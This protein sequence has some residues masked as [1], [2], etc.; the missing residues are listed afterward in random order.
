[1]EVELPLGNEHYINTNNSPV[2]LRQLRK[3]PNLWL[4][5][6]DKGHRFKLPDPAAVEVLTT[7]K[8]TRLNDF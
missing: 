5:Q 8:G 3:N 4:G 7:V 6:G 2:A 1:M